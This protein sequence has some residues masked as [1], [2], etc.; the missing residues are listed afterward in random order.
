[1]FVRSMRLEIME[2]PPAVMMVAIIAFPVLEYNMA[3]ERPVSIDAMQHPTAT[4]EHCS[5]VVIEC[6]I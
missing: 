3:H 1:M 5:S 6:Y 4:L 2:T